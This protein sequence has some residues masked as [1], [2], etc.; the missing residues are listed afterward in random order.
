[1]TKRIFADAISSIASITIQYS[2]NSQVDMRQLAKVVN[3]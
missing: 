3:K 1:M 2:F